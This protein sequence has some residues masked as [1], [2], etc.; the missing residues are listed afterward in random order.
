MCKLTENNHFSLVF[1]SKILN[2]SARKKEWID[3][4]FN[5]KCLSNLHLE[6]LIFVVVGN[7]EVF[8]QYQVHMQISYD[9][10]HIL[11]TDL[12]KMS[13]IN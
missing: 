10:L 12:R 4:E 3:C 2:Y 8:S 7:E 11:H 1:I 13:I 6:K 5:V 9:A